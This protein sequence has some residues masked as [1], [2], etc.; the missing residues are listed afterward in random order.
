MFE[1]GA[2]LDKLMSEDERMGAA[3]HEDIMTDPCVMGVGGH[4]VCK[5]GAPVKSG[6]RSRRTERWLE[7]IYLDLS[8]CILV[9]SSPLR[10]LD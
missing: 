8:L 10:A 1:T 3:A 9:F 4:L 7:S 6:A 5:A 2:N